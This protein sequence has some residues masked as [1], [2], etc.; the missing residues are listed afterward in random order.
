MS[1]HPEDA[2]SLERLSEIFE[3]GKGFAEDPDSLR[4]LIQLSKRLA[5]DTQ[6]G[7]TLVAIAELAGSLISIAGNLQ[8]LIGIRLGE[9]NLCLS[10]PD[11]G[12][13]ISVGGDPVGD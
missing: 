8:S 1:E 5:L 13:D 10:P 3:D 4:I 6:G 2:V 7:R 9:R 12:D 11:L